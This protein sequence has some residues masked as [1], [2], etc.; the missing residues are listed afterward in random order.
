[1]T[2][3]PTILVFNKY[4]LPGYRAGGPIRT[5]ANMVAR[6]GDEFNFHIVTLNHDA[7]EN[8]S[9]YEDIIPGEWSQ[10]GKAQVMYLDSATL[11]IRSLTQLISNLNPDV[12]YLNSFF[13]P[14]F[15]QRILL[16]KRLS[17]FSKIPVILATRGEFSDGAIK[18]KQVKKQLFLAAAKIVRL[19][20]G[21]TWQASS[22]LEREVILNNLCYV[23]K[24]CV[25]VAKNLAPLEEGAIFQLLARK[26][27]A[28]LRLCFLS[29]I[30]LMKNLDFALEALN[31]VRASIIL[32]IYGPK[33]DTAYW[34]NCEQL[35]AQLPKNVS[36]A[37]GGTVQ[38]DDV[39]QTMA[40]HDLFLLPTRGENYGH[41]IH[42][43]LCAGLPVLISD[44]TPWNEVTE[45]G[46]GWALPLDSPSEFARIIDEVASWVPERY[47]R[48]RPLAVEF[49]REKSVDND[50]LEA[51][52]N[53]FSA[54]ISRGRS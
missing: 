43:A 22:E 19:Y 38:P 34:T 51:N 29:R 8:S 21:L 44:Q 18:L 26:E 16:G 24:D 6:L 25:H 13:D 11:T 46:V 54:A 27:D 12:I 3:K 28:P 5:L 31:G 14:T 48:I 53:L 17:L 40:Q 52:R 32:T 7:G 39:K 35:I 9:P 1:M 2:I 33:E 10:V 23:K 36:V 15:T 30:S 20:D 4:Y 49:A 37:Y 50:V 42:E 41:V 45:R 47:A